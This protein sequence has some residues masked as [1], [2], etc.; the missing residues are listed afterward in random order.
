MSTISRWMQDLT[1][2]KG[3]KPLTPVQLTAETHKLSRQQ[4]AE[5]LGGMGVV[6]GWLQQAG[7]I[8]RL[9]AESL[10][11]SAVPLAGEWVR[12]DMHW[13]LEYT[14]PGEWQLHHFRLQPAEP[15]TATH[16]A[17]PVR[18][19]MV[20]AKSHESL[21]YR[22]LWEPDNTSG[23]DMAPVARIALFSGFE[24]SEE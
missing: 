8:Q 17:E 1:A 12:D 18:H 13:L 14:A 16:M 24:E 22:R 19:R 21:H 4:L 20:G 23:G 2:L 15:A 9:V 3:L 6:T 7:S 11:A 10:P 5:A